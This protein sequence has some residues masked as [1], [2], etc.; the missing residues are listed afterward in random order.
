MID[1]NLREKNIPVTQIPN[2]PKKWREKCVEI[3]ESSVQNKFIELK[4]YG[5][6]ENK[7]WLE[8]HLTDVAS[9]C[10]QVSYSVII[11]SVNQ[12]L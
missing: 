11:M 6:A 5:M 2:R 9:V 8:D 12:I 10:Y 7:D 3:M 1:D 4:P